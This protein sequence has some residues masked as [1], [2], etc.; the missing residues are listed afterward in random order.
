MAIGAGEADLPVP[1]ER[2]RAFGTDPVT[3]KD[4]G[5]EPSGD[6]ERV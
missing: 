2:V 3:G 5:C 4:T 1:G 6:R